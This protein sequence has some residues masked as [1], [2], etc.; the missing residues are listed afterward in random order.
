M[1]PI[2][3]EYEFEK[4]TSYSYNTMNMFHK[5][6]EL[7]VDSPLLIQ[8]R[9]E[10]CSGVFLDDIIKELKEVRSNLQDTLHCIDSY[11]ELLDDGVPSILHHC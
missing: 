5:V 10:G 7:F 3:I 2:N 9:D 4:N 6:L 8:V 11:L 1:L